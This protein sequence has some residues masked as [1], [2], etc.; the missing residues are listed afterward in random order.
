M[1]KVL[2]LLFCLLML[3]S[4]SNKKQD[5]LI[6]IRIGHASAEDATTQIV[7]EAFKEK[8]E[9]QL[10]NKV[11]VEIYPN[12]TLGSEAEMVEAIQMGS[13][14]A[15]TLGRHNAIDERMDVLNL[16]FLF[17]N[18][19]H[20]EKVL[21]GSEGVEIRNILNNMMKEHNI[22]CLGWYETGFREITSSVKIEKLED[23][24]GLLIRTPSTATLLESF[25]SWGASPTAVD[26][27]ELYSALQS[28]V[29]EAQENPY[30]LINTNKLYEVQDYLCISNH[31]TIPNQLIFSEKV[32][33][34]YSDE[35][36][37]AI[38]IAGEYACNVGGKRN[39]ELNNS[40]LS[41][42]SSKMTVTEMD[43]DSLLKM[44]AIAEE[45]V[46]PQFINKSTET[47]EIVDMIQSIK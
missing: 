12:A 9:E 20:V 4:C 32:W 17:E 31:L 5:D 21:R 2:I 39:V 43:S 11:K 45:E 1:K 36:K 46:W 23:L 44:K 25:K 18:D 15:A 33:N 47:K 6:L 35:V 27:S 41:E 8:L 14:D 19:E 16:P 37:E 10:G 30:Q 28:K 29:V 38:N 22:M 34:T 26:L 40:L 42:L 7:C 24:K 3:C 13:L